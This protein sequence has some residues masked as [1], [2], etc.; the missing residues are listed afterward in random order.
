[1]ADKLDEPRDILNELRGRLVL[2]K[3]EGKEDEKEKLSVIESLFKVENPFLDLS[4]EASYGI[5]E[6]LKVEE[7]DIPFVYNNLMSLNSKSKL[8]N[9]EGS[10]L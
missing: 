7:D 8:L 6:F 3:L 2:R 9:N 10:K 5:L 1:M 4:R